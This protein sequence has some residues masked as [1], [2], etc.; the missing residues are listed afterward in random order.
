MKPA[1]LGATLSFI[2]DISIVRAVNI[3]GCPK[4]PLDVKQR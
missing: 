2:P 3:E 1:P 4:N